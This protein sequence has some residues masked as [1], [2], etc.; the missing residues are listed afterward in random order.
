MSA[1]FWTTEI[2]EED[3]GEMGGAVLRVCIVSEGCYPYTVGGV[4]GWIHSMIQSFPNLEFMLVNIV[5]DREQR[6]KFVYELPD[7]VT[8]VYEVY[9]QDDD[10]H[11]VRFLK[12][13]RLKLKKKEWSALR[14]L[15]LN[16]SVEWDVLFE[17]FRGKRI[18]LN[19]LLMG[20]DFLRIAV[21]VYQKRY[22]QIMFS[23]FLWTLRSMYVP[24]F[25]V[26]KMEIPEADVYHCMAAGYAGIIG[27]M[28]SHFYGSRLLLSEH[29]IYTRERE[30]ELIRADWL[31]GLYKNIWIEQF[32]KMS[33]LVYARADIVIS[34][35]A[36]ARELQIELGCPPQKAEI[37]PNGI[38]VARLEGLQ[39]K[40]EEEQDSIYVGA[41]LRVTPI[42]DVKTL[43]KA[44]GNAKKLIPGLKLWIMGPVDEESGYALECM[45]L[46]QNLGIQDVFFTGSV[47]IREY[48][49][50]MDFTILTSISEGQPLTILESYAAGK[51]VIATD[52]GNCRGLIYG[53]DGDR[54]G[55]AG[56][57]T[58]VMNLDEITDA[59]VE[60]ARYP[61][62]R[63]D[64]GQNG[65]QRVCARHRI[66][67]MRHAYR[68]I[69]KKFSEERSLDWTEETFYIRKEGNHGRNRS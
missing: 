42:K 58:H 55:R 67:D 4:S 49:G 35:Y 53:E 54:F 15:M 30:E 61:E 21:E 23:D 5:S 19:E 29:G 56:I 26:M 37:I 25:L 1:F 66:E 3:A 39:G 32:R 57:L 14:S 51:P 6:G 13:S 8:R 16:Q 28:A 48:L 12:R 59:I 50:K 44:F 27:S 38:D 68:E 47:D 10:W 43:I 65:C 46:V 62:E 41:I 7:N 2:S 69:Y 45:E 34:L 36:H 9:L 60:L 18:S 11:P 33:T 52:V 17:L 63:R 31:D 20:E 40:T 64:Y 22:T 24:L